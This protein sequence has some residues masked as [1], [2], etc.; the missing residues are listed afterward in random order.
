MEFELTT[1]IASQALTLA[2]TLPRV[3]SHAGPGLTGRAALVVLLLAAAS[4]TWWVA[5][6]RAARFRSAHS[7]HR[8]HLAPQEHP[9]TDTTTLTA[10]DLGNPLGARATFVQFS[11]QTCASCPRVHRVLTSLTETEPDVVHVDL[12]AEDHMDLV[13]RF[14]V[15]RTPTVLLLDARGAVH[16][17]T[18]GPLTP[19]R[20]LA[21]LAQLTHLTAGST[22][23]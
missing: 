7:S 9:V 20:A 10:A 21:A 11:A 16:S 14:S 12:P 5:S 19:N 23:A 15:F 2:G 3:V 13:R 1:L 4:S 6:R 18:S 22:N 8:H 17:R